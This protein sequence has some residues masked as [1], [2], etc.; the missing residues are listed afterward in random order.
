MASGFGT[1][2]LNH[3]DLI[4]IILLGAGTSKLLM[5]MRRKKVM[6]CYVS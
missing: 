3:G 2:D 5:S 1:E 6:T 4:I